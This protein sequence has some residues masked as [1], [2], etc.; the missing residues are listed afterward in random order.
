MISEASKKIQVET[1]VL[2]YWEDE[3]KLPISR[4]EL[5]HRY[6]R[7]TDIELLKAV[8]KLK[9]QGFQLKAVKMLLPNINKL[10]SLDPQTMVRLKDELNERVIG[11]ED[12]NK[13][14]EEDEGTSLIPREDEDGIEESSHDKMGKFKTIMMQLIS[15]ALKE[16]N[17]LLAEQVTMNVTDGVTKEVNFLLRLQDEKE[18]ER[19][20][21]FD[22]TL[23]EYQKSRTLVAATSEGKNKKKSKFFKKNRAYI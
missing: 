12:T 20:K 2:R 18:E 19:F 1:H 5:G 7:E 13:E 10:D 21:R 6:Y 22:A 14:I 4:N 8:K 11:M 17:T 23:R 15:V 3:L 9:E 16:N